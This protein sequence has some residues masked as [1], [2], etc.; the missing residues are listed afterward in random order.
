MKDSRFPIF[1]VLILFVGAAYA[2][3][4]PPLFPKDPF[5]VPAPTVEE[6]VRALA[7]DGSICKVYGHHWAT[8]LFHDGWTR[9]SVPDGWFRRCRLCSHT[10]NDQ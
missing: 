2:A 10:E 3:V 8:S 1:L 6:T 7:E 4:F 9:I 5:E